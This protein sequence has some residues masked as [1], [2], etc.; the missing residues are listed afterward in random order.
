MACQ[1][2]N[3]KL[4]ELADHYRN[5]ILIPA[6]AAGGTTPRISA[7]PRR[8]ED[9]DVEEMLGSIESAK[10]QQEKLRNQLLIRDNSRCVLTQ[11]IE[12]HSVP[13]DSD[14]E[15]THY[16]RPT[17]FP[18]RLDVSLKMWLVLSTSSFTTIT[19]VCQR[20]NAARIWV[21]L[22]RVFPS[23]TTLTPE[24]IDDPSNALMMCD[25]LHT[26]FGQFWFCLEPLEI[27]KLRKFPN[28]YSP[29]LPQDR[30]VRLVNHSNPFS[31]YIPLP[32]KKYL[33]A[34]AAV[35]KILYATDLGESLD[36]ALCEGEALTCFAEDGTN[37]IYPLLVA[38]C[39]ALRVR[40]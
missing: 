6:H 20:H 35:A 14:V 23:L 10:R 8:N 24:G 33:E 13:D 4:R 36:K 25:T 28:V 34:H 29:L 15:T 18:S 3:P 1:P 40:F 39:A 9:E 11:M 7:S 37:D 2:V 31:N 26:V 16:K 19:D 17:Y 22:R 5:A 12:D 38:R 32:N 21:T 27:V 30:I